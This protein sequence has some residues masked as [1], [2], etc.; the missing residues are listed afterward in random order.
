MT[1]AFIY[2][3]SSIITLSV[4]AGV[5]RIEDA[6]GGQLLVLRRVRGFFDRV[7]LWLIMCCTWIAAYIRH[8]FARLFFHYLA[9]RLLKRLYAVTH[10]LE[11]KTEE[12]LRQNKRTA[13]RISTERQERSHLDEI[14]DHKERTSLSDA[15]IEKM[16]SLD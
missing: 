7:V 5:F 3:A 2:L 14:A 6:Q 4:I 12:L 16:R 9:H 8:S 1:T 11:L 10:R 13:R 15:Q